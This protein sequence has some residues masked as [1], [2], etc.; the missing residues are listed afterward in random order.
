MFFLVPLNE[1]GSVI[2]ENLVPINFHLNTFEIC[3]G[4]TSIPRIGLLSQK[5]LNS[6]RKLCD[7]NMLSPTSI[8]D[9]LRWVNSF[10][11]VYGNADEIISPANQL[12][13]IV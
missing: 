7:I 13:N 9:V 11:L 10:N 1:V 2:F 8:S 3:F 12:T 4:F 6:M 5:L